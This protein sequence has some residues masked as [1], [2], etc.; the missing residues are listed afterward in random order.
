MT[1]RRPPDRR[2]FTDEVLDDRMATI[3]REKTPAERLAIAFRLWSFARQMI[4]RMT[5]REHPEWSEQEVTH[6]V[7]G[8]MSHGAV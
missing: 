8:R 1:S 5:V 2:T 6:H 3:L 7:A 4:H